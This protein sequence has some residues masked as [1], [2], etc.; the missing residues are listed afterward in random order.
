ME[1]NVRSLFSTTAFDSQR[2]SHYLLNEWPVK[3][4]QDALECRGLLPKLPRSLWVGR[5]Q[6]VLG[7]G[8]VPV[9]HAARPT[10]RG[11]PPLLAP[12]VVK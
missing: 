1:I 10:S 12:S 4:L 8:S 2:K 7:E 9:T 6:C 5:D 11:P 3:P